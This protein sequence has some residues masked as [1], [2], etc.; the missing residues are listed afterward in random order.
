MSLFGITATDLQ[1]KVQPVNGEQTFA[2]GEEGDLS[3]ERAEEIIRTAED[4]VLMRLPHRYRQLCRHVD[5]EVLIRSASGGERVFQTGLAPISDLLL[6]LNFPG[7]R[8]YSGRDR[9]LALPEEAYSYTPETGA[10]ELL[11]GLQPSDRLWAEYDHEAGHR[12]LALR[13][14]AMTLAA[15]EVARR[16]AFFAR[17]D[18]DGPDVFNDWEQSAYGDLNRM[19]CVDVLDRLNLVR[20][21]EPEQFYSFVEMME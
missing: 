6:Y 18:S 5:G 3:T 10:I 17:G 15:V 12:L 7:S 13:D 20:E 1:E 16:M 8:M 19:Q 9:S 21:T 11:N 2:I 14:V 4:R